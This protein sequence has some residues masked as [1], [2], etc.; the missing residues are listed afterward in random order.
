MLLPFPVSFLT[1]IPLHGSIDGHDCA[2]CNFYDTC[3]VLDSCVRVCV[4]ILPLKQS[5][6]AFLDVLLSAVSLFEGA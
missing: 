5:N 4:H 3:N 1:Q 2:L 6:S